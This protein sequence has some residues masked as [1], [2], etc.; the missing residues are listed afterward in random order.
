MHQTLPAVLPS[1]R[2]LALREDDPV[3]APGGGKSTGPALAEARLRL[4]LVSGSQ[5]RE[6]WNTRLLDD[7]ADRLAGMSGVAC[8]ID[9]LA[10]RE[11]D[12]PLFD[13]DIE[14]DP[15][16]LARV[17]ALHARVRDAHG[18]LVASPEYNGQLTPWL[19]NLVDWVSRLA[20]VDP[21]VEPP[22]TDR[23]L[24]LCSASTGWS[25]GTLGLVHA[26]ALFGYV[27]ANVIGDTLSLPHAE[28]A[29]SDFGYLFDEAFELRIDAALGRLLRLAGQR[30]SASAPVV[31]RELTCG[32]SLILPA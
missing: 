10:P 5:R 9:L 15:A 29:W 16:V 4:L 6:S 22:F 17:A 30:A 11:V 18:L 2:P 25:G 21:T 3:P 31:A 13:Q 19:K 26:R 1:T 28:Q 7:L 12:L 24:L 8:Q 23:P 32:T 14:T 27:G 20:H